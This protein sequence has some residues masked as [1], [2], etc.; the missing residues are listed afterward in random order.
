MFIKKFSNNV[1]TF[2]DFDFDNEIND[3]VTFSLISEIISLLAL[4]ALRVFRT[5]HNL[6]QIFH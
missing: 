6:L 5:F 3:K 4:L 1:L 2:D